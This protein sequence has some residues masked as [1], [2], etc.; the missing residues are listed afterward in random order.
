MTAPKTP[1]LSAEPKTP[2]LTPSATITLT[3]S[4]ESWA[5]G[6]SVVDD[7]LGGYNHSSV[8]FKTTFTDSASGKTTSVF[9]T[10]D[11]SGQAMQIATRTFGEAMIRS[12]IAVATHHGVGSGNDSMIVNTAKA[13]KAKVV[14][15]PRGSTGT[16]GA[17]TFTGRASNLE[18]ISISKEA[19]YAGKCEMYT[20]IPVPYE[21]GST[22]IQSS[23]RIK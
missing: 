18:L 2:P 10:G 7:T 20:I 15:F 8:I 1:H 21:Y 11:G 14:L 9:N 19:F 6:K 3:R 22:V 23:T 17:S 13:I 5:D 16:N 12:D 4:S